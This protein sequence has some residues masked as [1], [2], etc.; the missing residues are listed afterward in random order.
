MIIETT[1]ENKLVKRK[2]DKD[3]YIKNIQTGYEYT[4]AI[5]LPNEE[6]LKRGLKPYSYEETDKAI[7]VDIYSPLSATI[8]E[9]AI[10]YDIISGGAV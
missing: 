5:D 9:K 7:E 2:S 1:L 8:L 4:E 10:A 6:R 3:V